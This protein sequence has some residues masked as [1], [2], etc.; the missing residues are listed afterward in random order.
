MGWHGQ[1]RMWAIQK[2]DELSALD[3]TISR[4]L[5]NVRA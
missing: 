2:M 4:L 1:R 3:V 5:G